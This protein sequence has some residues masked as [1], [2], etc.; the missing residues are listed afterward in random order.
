MANN[1]ENIIPNSERTP[2]ERKAIAT[3]GGIASGV[4]RREK[5]TMR[6]WA[7]VFGEMGIKVA[8]PD[9][10][11]MDTDFD[12]AVVFAQYQ[13]AIKN[14]DTKSAQFLADLKGETEQRLDINSNAP[15]VILRESEASTLEKLKK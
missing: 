6:K 13:K 4:A 14:S 3:A 12:G 1:P 10:T 5:R 15:V 9:G 7:E 2:E 8:R 11:M